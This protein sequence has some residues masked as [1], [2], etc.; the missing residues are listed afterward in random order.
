MFATKVAS[1]DNHDVDVAVAARFLRS[2]NRAENEREFPP[3]MIASGTV[4]AGQNVGERSLAR[5][6]AKTRRLAHDTCKL[7]V[8]RRRCDWPYRPIDWR[9]TDSAMRMPA[10]ASLLS[11]L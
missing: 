1:A 5:M 8:N 4:S 10:S 6:S 2:G 7:I 11:S 3:P 9:D